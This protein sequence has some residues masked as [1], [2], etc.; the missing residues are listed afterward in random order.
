MLGDQI[1][2]LRKN[3]GMSQLQLAEKLNVGASAVGMYEQGRR[4]P[5]IE[6]LVRLA[7]QFNVSLDYLITG[8]ESLDSKADGSS[9]TMQLECPY[10][11]HCCCRNNLNS[12]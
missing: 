4:T 12:K 9:K 6:I 8:T 1:K 10:R 5:A 11:G 7:E 3:A 2:E